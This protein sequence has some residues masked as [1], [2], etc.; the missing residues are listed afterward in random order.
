[1]EKAKSKSNV[2]STQLG[3]CRN[4]SKPNLMTYI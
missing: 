1:M 4:T 2:L 3:T